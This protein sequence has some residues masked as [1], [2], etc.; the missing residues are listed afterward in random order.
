LA[1]VLAMESMRQPWQL[2]TKYASE[3]CSRMLLQQ[4]LQ[5]EPLQVH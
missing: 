5:L 2:S 1:V 4:S 3:R